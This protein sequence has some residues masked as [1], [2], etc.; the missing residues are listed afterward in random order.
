MSKIERLNA[1]VSKLLTVAVQEVLEVVRETVSE[2]QEKTA[3]TQREN[4]RLRRRL[5]ELQ[6]KVTRVN[7]AEQSAAFPVSGVKALKQQ[8]EWSSSLQQDTELTL[9]EEKREL[10]EE[11]RTREREEDRSGLELD[12]LA[13]SEIDCDIARCFIHSLRQVNVPLETYGVV[14]RKPKGSSRMSKIE[15]LNARVSKLLTVAVQ[16]VLE[17]VRETVSEYQEKTA[18]TQRE[19]ERLRRR[20]QELQD[21]VTRVNTGAEQPVAPHVPA[22]KIPIEQQEW[23]SSLQQDTELTL[24]EEK[25]ELSEEQRTREREEDRSGL[26]L[27]HLAE[28]EIDCD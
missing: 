3:R 9:T 18:R 26:E 20:L 5:Q 16:E 10:T 17:V 24:T 6:D 13:E 15:R 25:Q 12:H 2:Y 14:E 8:Q 27:D 28:S 11:Q 22:M 1:R 4:E 23:S 7:T 19:N 21:K